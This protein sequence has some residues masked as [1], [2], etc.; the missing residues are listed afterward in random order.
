MFTGL[1]KTSTRR[2]VLTLKPEK[3]LKGTSSPQSTITT[4]STLQ[5]HLQKLG[6][7]VHDLSGS[8]PSEQEKF[9]AAWEED[10]RQNL[11]EVGLDPDD[12]EAE[13]QE[14]AEPP[15]EEGPQ[16][17]KQGPEGNPAVERSRK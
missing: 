13:A 14:G 8:Q 10:L 1:E 7:E 11:R 4:P 2:T 6:V 15:E 9:R 16:S 12:L 3:K 5:E 17:R